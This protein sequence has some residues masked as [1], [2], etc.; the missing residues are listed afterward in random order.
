[1]NWSLFNEYFD[2][3]YVIT[4]RRATERHEKIVQVLEGLAF[5]FFYGADAKEFNPVD[6]IEAN[7]YDKV[8]AKKNNRYNKEMKPGEIGC[9]WSHL[10]V[11]KDMVNKGYEKVLILEDDVFPNKEAEITFINVVKELPEEWELLYMDY[12]KNLENSFANKIKRKFY[13]L[14]KKACALNF[15]HTTINNLHAKPYSQHLKKS[16]YHD[17][18]S[19][20]AI[21]VSAAKKLIELQTPIK[22]VADH[23]LAYAIT[24]ELINGYTSVP[25][26]F[27]QE[28]QTNKEAF[29]SYI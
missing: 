10:L 7:I 27:L 15:S 1:M 9:S 3:I 23:L 26:I 28:S 25:K 6:L 22:F 5:D 29:G 11:Y 16:G 18:T 4:L 20:Y 19:A 2:H 21:K 17:Y 14:Q 24:N 8:A 13:H 12:N